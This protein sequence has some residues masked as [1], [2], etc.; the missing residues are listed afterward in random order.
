MNIGWIVFA[1]GIIMEIYG[2]WCLMIDCRTNRRLVTGTVSGFG[3]L[4]LVFWS[5]IYFNL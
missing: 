2:Q 4:I 1:L 5:A 3:G